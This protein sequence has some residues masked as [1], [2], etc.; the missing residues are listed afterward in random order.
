MRKVLMSAIAAVFTLG[1]A[2]D[3][4]PVAAAEGAALPDK[5][6]GFEGMN[7]KFDNAARQRGFQVFRE[8][9]S[10]CHSLDLI[11]FRNLAAL[12]YNEDEIKAIAADYTVVDGPDDEGEMFERPGKPSDRWP[13]P[14]ANAK[15][16]AASN[17]GAVPPDLTL[18]TKARKGGPTYTYALLT[19]YAEL[20]DDWE[21]FEEFE[22]LKCPEVEE[23]EESS[24]QK[25]AM[26]EGL[27][28]NHYFPG[29]QIAMAAPLSEDAV[30]YA[31]GTPATVEQMASDV[32]EFLAW[33]AEPELEERKQMGWKVM[34]F[35][36]ILVGMLYAVKRR[37]WANLH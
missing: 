35:L 22:Y 16:A 17:G 3:G 9:C 26:L 28:F 18:M 27:S 14:F 31:D 36:L 21:D 8:V 29:H 33:T 32:V 13:A 19:G 1:L 23:D 6:W 25:F 4:G 24:C 20:P 5:D 10:A 11:N 34:I 7:G 15:A 37:I 30:E 2:L 12:G